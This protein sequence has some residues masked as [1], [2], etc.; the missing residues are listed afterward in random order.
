MAKSAGRNYLVKKNGTTIASVR[1]KSVN[2]SSQM[3]DVTTDD[4]TGD[5]TYLA[6]VLTGKAL[7]CSVEGLT[8]DDVFSDIAF[9]TTDADKFLDDLTIE[10]PNGDEISGTFILSAYTETGAYQDAVTFTAT[11]TRSGAHTFA[12]A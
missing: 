6:D 7:E 2:W 3:I 10:R 5:T 9:S 11:L 4:D 1:Q 8:N 12:E